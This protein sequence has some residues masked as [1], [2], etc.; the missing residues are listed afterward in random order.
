[1]PIILRKR[2]FTFILVYSLLWITTNVAVWI[3]IDN[4]TATVVNLFGA[5][6]FGVLCMV[7]ISLS[8]L[9]PR[10]RD[11]LVGDWLTEKDFE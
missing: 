11:W 1:M 9:K 5:L 8:E 3:S 4:N 7:M 10:I 2:W 6:G